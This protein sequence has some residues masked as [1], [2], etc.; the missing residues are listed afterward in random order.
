M[1]IFFG[2]DLV[3]RSTVVP[4]CKNC[5]IKKG[6]NLICSKLSVYSTVQCTVYNNSTYI[7]ICALTLWLWPNCGSIILGLFWFCKNFADLLVFYIWY[8]KTWKIENDFEPVPNFVK[9][10][11]FFRDSSQI[12]IHFF[13]APATVDL[14]TKSPKNKYV[15]VQCNMTI[16]SVYK[17]KYIKEAKNEAYTQN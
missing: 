3:C 10:F 8:S 9:H 16:N 6:K 15:W 1:Y 14:R 11:L 2:S 4:S 12:S 13:I 7:C 17:I 5:N